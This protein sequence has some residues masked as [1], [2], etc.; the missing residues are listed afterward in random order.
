MDSHRLAQKGD[1]TI[2]VAKD[3]Y[4]KIGRN[5]RENSQSRRIFKGE[6]FYWDFAEKENNEFGET[7]Y[8]QFVENDSYAVSSS[9]ESNLKKDKKDKFDDPFSNIQKLAI[10]RKTDGNIELKLVLYL[11]D[12][13][14][15][16]NENRV[17][18]K[19]DG[20]ILFFDTNEILIDGLEYKNGKIENYFYNGN[21]ANIGNSNGRRCVNCFPYYIDWY[22]YAYGGGYYGQYKYMY[23]ATY[24]LCIPCSGGSGNSIT[25][26][27]TTGG[28]AGSSSGSFA[29]DGAY[30]GANNIGIPY[31]PNKTI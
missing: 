16:K 29:P 22:S 28:S 11:P 27:G 10:T 6:N 5:K 21:D 30:T 31:D 18:E 9:D 13:A 2:E 3:W 1:F 12:K 14:V 8:V 15:R 4:T 17:F 20:K 26:T 19:F 23:T 25:Q 7:F 24:Q